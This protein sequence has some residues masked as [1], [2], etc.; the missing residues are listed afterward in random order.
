MHEEDTLLR[1]T[2]GIA[3]LA[4]APCILLSAAVWFT[5]DSIGILIANLFQVYFSI[6][7]LFLSVYIWSLKPNFE[8]QY[9]SQLKIIATKLILLVFLG[10]TLSI[11]TNP[12]WGI[13]FLMFGF[14]LIRF[15]RFYYSI[16]QV[17]SKTYIDLLN[18]ISIILCIC[19]MLIFAYW[20][21][22]YSN[23]LETNI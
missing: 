4:I 8:E 2:R 15:I 17:I 13:G 1:S 5:S 3:Y 19:L 21:N 14:Y 23:P 18:R 22:P 10:I 7:M 12:A 20:L 9:K 6:L 16:F 11:S